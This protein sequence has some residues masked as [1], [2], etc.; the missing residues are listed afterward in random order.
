MDASTR[1]REK[2]PKGV[3]NPGIYLP[4]KGT[5]ERIDALSLGNTGNEVMMVAGWIY[6]PNNSRRWPSHHLDYSELVGRSWKVENMWSAA[7]SILPV[8]R[9]SQVVMTRCAD[10]LVYLASVARQPFLVCLFC[11]PTGSRMLCFGGG[12]KKTSLPCLSWRA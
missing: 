9:G 3:I 1:A 4:H 5:W 12:S 2:L 10:G 8:Q 11:C 6:S 7:I